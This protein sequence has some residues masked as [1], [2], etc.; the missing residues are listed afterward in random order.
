MLPLRILL[1][2]SSCWTKSVQIWSS[3]QF[4]VKFIAKPSFHQVYIKIIKFRCK[5]LLERTVV[6]SNS[7]CHFVITIA[8]WAVHFHL[9]WLLWN[10]K[11]KIIYH[12]CLYRW[13]P[14][15]KK[16][17]SP[18]WSYWV[19]NFCFWIIL[20]IILY[21]T[22]PNRIINLFEKHILVNIYKQILII[23][24]NSNFDI[25]NSN[26]THSVSVLVTETSAQ[27]YSMAKIE[28]IFNLQ[29]LH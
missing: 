22:N 18:F 17:L 21:I 16:D 1:H 13:V 11:E 15:L 14:S 25:N 10:Q 24:L 5:Y 29:H 20:L 9:S 19:L 6:T 2:S 7:S 12:L 26:I 8:I 4:K 28:L 27:K 3:F 23:L